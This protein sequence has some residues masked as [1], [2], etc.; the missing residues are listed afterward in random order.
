MAS[1]LLGETPYLII[2]LMQP[3]CKARPG[4]SPTISGLTL[5]GMLTRL[6]FLGLMIQTGHTAFK[7]GWVNFSLYS[8][9]FLKN[10]NKNWNCL[11]L[12][13]TSVYKAR[14]YF[15]G[16]S[17]GKTNLPYIGTLI[18]EYLLSKIKAIKPAMP[19][20]PKVH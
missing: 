6:L 17:Q 10:K 5:G 11:V 14:L 18:Q 9:L 12:V 15:K 3:R 19:D 2:R 8:L 7:P 20:Q 13:C 4:D 16:P 1:Y